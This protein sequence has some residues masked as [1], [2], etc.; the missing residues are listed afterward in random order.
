MLNVLY[1]LKDTKDRWNAMKNASRM[2]QTG[3]ILFINDSGANGKRMLQQHG[4]PLPSESFEDMLG[5]TII[6]D[7]QRRKNSYWTIFRKVT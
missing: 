7:V 2:L 3:G 5:L 1:Q 6:E 4:G